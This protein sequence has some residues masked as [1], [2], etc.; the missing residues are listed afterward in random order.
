MAHLFARS[1]RRVDHG[2]SCL[3]VVDPL[4]ACESIL[5]LPGADR[6]GVGGPKEFR[7]VVRIKRRPTH[8]RAGNRDGC[9]ID[10]VLLDTG[11]EQGRRRAQRPSP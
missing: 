2:P 8:D 5:G 4:G 3:G 11:G 6:V 9:G 10:A 1:P 7:D